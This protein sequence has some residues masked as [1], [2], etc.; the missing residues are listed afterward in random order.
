MFAAVSLEQAAKAAFRSP[1]LG[2]AVIALFFALP[3]I[4]LLRGGLV[5]ENR[6]IIDEQSSAYADAP[7]F[8]GTAIPPEENVFELR[9]FDK[10]YAYSGG[11]A[12]DAG[13]VL[14]DASQVV[15]YVPDDF[16]PDAYVSDIRTVNPRLTSMERL[17]VAYYSTCYLLSE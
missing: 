3:E 11:N 4:S 7:C 14:S 1:L 9:K 6:R 5:D 13:S 8:F 15:V 17:Y 16:D 10:I 2:L 12:A